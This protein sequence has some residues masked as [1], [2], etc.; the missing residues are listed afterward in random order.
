MQRDA[1]CPTHHSPV[2]E[3][4]PKSKISEMIEF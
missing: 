3:T 4:P 1:V 2:R